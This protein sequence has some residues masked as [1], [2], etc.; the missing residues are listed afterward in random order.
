MD[1]YVNNTHFSNINAYVI[2]TRDP[3]EVI[4]EVQN[5]GEDAYE[6]HTVVELPEDVDYINVKP[7]QV[8][9]DNSNY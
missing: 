4:I 2:G 7:I 8:N 5:L 3:L 1:F 6:A 9:T